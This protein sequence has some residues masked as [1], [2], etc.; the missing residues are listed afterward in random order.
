MK[1]LVCIT[2]TPD[3]TAPVTFSAD[4][5]QYNSAGVQFIINP[6]DEWY[7]LV[8][9]VELK[10]A[11]G[12]TVTV[13]NVGPK[14]NEI[15]IRRAI[16]IGADEAARIDA[17]PTSARFVAQQIADF[18]QKG[19]FDVIFLG[20]ETIDFNGSEV[21]GMV[22]ELLDMP[23]ISY[24]SKLDLSGNTATVTRDI[25][26]GTEVVQVDAPFVVSASKG[27]AEQRIANM[28]AIMM[29]K[30]KPLATIAATPVAETSAITQFSLPPAKSSVQMLEPDQM[31]ELVRL[32]H[33]DAKVI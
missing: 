19:G 10:E 11:L 29:A 14:D 21:G 6:Y 16:A 12:G 17:E 13:L 20:K 31:A 4:H 18:A 22:A 24:A 28:R 25:E 27:M 5:T 9:A 2:K 7:A 3:T 26:G 23:F 1:F 33:E 30:S 15:L 32:L 8:R